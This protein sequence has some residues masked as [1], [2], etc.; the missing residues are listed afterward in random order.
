MIWDT[1]RG[2]GRVATTG[3]RNLTQERQ[4]GIISRADVEVR[5]GETSQEMVSDAEIIALV[6][7]NTGVEATVA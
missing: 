4:G 1:T 2:S 6:N 7:S 5:D 3:V